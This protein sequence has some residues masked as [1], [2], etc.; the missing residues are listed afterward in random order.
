MKYTVVCPLAVK[1]VDSYFIGL[2]MLDK[3]IDVKRFVVIG[4]HEVEER[5]NKY[6]DSRVCFENE[7]QFISYSALREIIAKYTDRDESSMK[8]TGWYLQQFLKLSYSLI[9]D[10]EYYLLWDADTIPIHKHE[11][12]EDGHP[13]FDMKT[14]H[15]EPY[16][17]TF[18]RIFP[19]YWKRNK[20]SYISEHMLVRTS[21]MR[22]MIN[23]IEKSDL[24]GASW[25]EKIINCIEKKDIAESG[26]ADYETY[27]LYCLNKYPDLYRERI[28]D[29]LRP[30]SYYFAFD[31]MRECDYEWLRK[32]YDA[33][34]FEAKREVKKH[35]NIICRNKWIQKHFSCKR[36]LKSLHQFTI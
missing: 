16:F 10:D 31:E 19:N 5:I 20:L 28:W 9:C 2:D 14:E 29:S 24:S 25:H 1:D 36:L 23:E 7:E 6:G 32:D 18:S 33:V 22:E 34:S 12:I 17:A 26:F 30:A 11:M 13:V 8:R 21:I 15:H 27:G 35:I 4:N 3:Y